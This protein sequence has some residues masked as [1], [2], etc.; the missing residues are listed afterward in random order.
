MQGVGHGVNRSSRSGSPMAPDP[1]NRG[2]QSPSL[3]GALKVVQRHQRKLHEVRLAHGRAIVK[4]PTQRSDPFI[5]R[6]GRSRLGRRLSPDS[7]CSIARS[8]TLRLLAVQSSRRLGRTFGNATVRRT[9]DA[10]G[11]LSTCSCN[12]SRDDRDHA[13]PRTE[14][15]PVHASGRSRHGP[16]HLNAPAGGRG[17]AVPISSRTMPGP[18]A[19]QGPPLGIISDVARQV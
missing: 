7:G 12:G 19:L 13:G 11:G 5:R 15:L 3:C 14:S 10:P 2:C 4:L 17:P 8:R 16:G 6:D 18:S 1:G 9:A